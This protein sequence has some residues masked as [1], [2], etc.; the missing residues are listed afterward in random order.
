MSP[1]EGAAPFPSSNSRLKCS[2]FNNTMRIYSFIT[3]TMSDFCMQLVLMNM[4]V[5]PELYAN[6]CERLLRRQCLVD[7]KIARCRSYDRTASQPADQTRLA[8][9]FS[10]WLGLGGHVV[11]QSLGRCMGKRN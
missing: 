8:Q 3:N 11:A 9:R 7:F 4:N 6:R 10:G 5:S 2:R 1:E